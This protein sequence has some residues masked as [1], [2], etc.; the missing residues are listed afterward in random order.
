MAPKRTIPPVLPLV[1][2]GRVTA[3][4]AVVSLDGSNGR[5]VTLKVSLLEPIKKRTSA[6]INVNEQRTNAHATW[7]PQ[8]EIGATI[9]AIT[10][11]DVHVLATVTTAEMT[12][13]VM[14][15]AGNRLKSCLL[16]CPEP[17]LGRAVINAFRVG[18]QEPED[19]G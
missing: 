15:A 2:S 9:T 7:P 8:G 5:A 12:A 16:S 4:D 18:T 11:D 3:W 19:L 1:V 14:L 10:K 6:V 13:L 17:H